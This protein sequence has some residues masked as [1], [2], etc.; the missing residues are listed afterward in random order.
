[1]IHLDV[2]EQKAGICDIRCS[3]ILSVLKPSRNRQDVLQ[4]CQS[5][6]KTHRSW[7][8]PTRDSAHFVQCLNSW[9]SI[10]GSSM[11]VLQADPRA[12]DRTK[13]LAVEV[14]SL[15]SATSHKVMWN[16]SEVSS[17]KFQ[18]SMANVF[19]NLIHQALQSDPSI[20]L[21]EPDLMDITKFQSDH[22]EEEW[23]DLLCMIFLRIPKCFV[24]VEVKD[25]YHFSNYN[26]IRPKQL[27]DTFQL[28]VDKVSSGKS[29]IKLLVVSYGTRMARCLDPSVKTP[30]I[31]SR[32]GHAPPPSRRS[33]RS[34]GRMVGSGLSRHMAVPRLMPPRTANISKR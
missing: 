31:V 25:L 10:S 14:T 3:Q 2:R 11:F 4:R 32:I 21:S 20:I 30:R 17:S 12:E 6:A 23:L 24:I 27:L 16:L 34:S 9:M 13:D 5:V 18:S 26:P 7:T 19:K 15:L 8:L 29:I 22:T 28:I 33:K 1:M